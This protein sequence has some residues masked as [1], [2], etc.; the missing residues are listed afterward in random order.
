MEILI[1]CSARLGLES[2]VGR[3]SGKN[4]ALADVDSHEY[5]DLRLCWC[6]EGESNP[7]DLAVAGF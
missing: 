5:D 4:E 7:H 2:V 3:R 6:R 1:G